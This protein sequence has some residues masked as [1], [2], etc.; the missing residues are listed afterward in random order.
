MTLS[1]LTGVGS[2]VDL[3]FKVIAATGLV[4]IL[5]LNQYY[6]TRSDFRDAMIQR[7]F[8]VDKLETKVDGAVVTLNA[9]EREI[10]VFKRQQEINSNDIGDLRRERKP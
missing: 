8:S 4:L 2:F 9:I 6:V 10:A 5:W 1:K 3:V 7:Q